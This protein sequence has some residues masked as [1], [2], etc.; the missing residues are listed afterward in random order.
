VNG[1]EWNSDTCS[2]AAECGHLSV[3]Q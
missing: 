2:S 1:C 3:L